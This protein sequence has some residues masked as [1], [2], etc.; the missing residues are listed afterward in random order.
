MLR[1]SDATNPDWRD[2]ERPRGDAIRAL[3]GDVGLAGRMGSTTI[4]IIRTRSTHGGVAVER[5]TRG[6]RPDVPA[7]AVLGVRAAHIDTSA[8]T[9]GRES[10]RTRGGPDDGE[11]DARRRTTRH[12]ATQRPATAQDHQPLSAPVSAAPIMHIMSTSRERARRLP[13]PASSP[14]RRPAACCGSPRRPSVV[15][16]ADAARDAVAP[17]GT[18][19]RRAAASPRCAAPSHRPRASRRTSGPSARSA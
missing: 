8:R 11:G 4:K 12:P 17:G 14:G 7:R 15:A 6:R 9:A 3:L 1:H 18:P 16:D 19:D 5:V 10:A 2:R 13:P